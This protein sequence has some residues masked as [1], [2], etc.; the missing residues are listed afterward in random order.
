MP[1]NITLCI[2]VLNYKVLCVYFCW[3]TCHVLACTHWYTSTGGVL[4]YTSTG[5]GTGVVLVLEWYWYV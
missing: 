3:Y 5:T 1:F 2:V 4:V